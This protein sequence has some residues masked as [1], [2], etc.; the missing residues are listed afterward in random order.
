MTLW[1]CS[2]CGVEQADTEQPAEL[3]AICIDDRQYIRPS[4]QAWTTLAELEA[5]GRTGAVAEV[6]PGLHGVTVTPGVGIGQRSFLVR[7]EHGNLLWDPVGYLDDELV[8]QV[9]AVGGVAAIAASHPHMF[10]VQTEWSRRFDGAPVYVC[11]PDEEWIQR[12]DEVIRR[13][14]D[15]I[16]V[17]PGIRLLQVGGHFRG[18]AVAHLVGADGEG[19]LLSGDTA[20]GTPDQKWASFLRSYPNKIPLSANTVRRIADRLAELSFDR[21]Y[22]N[23]QGLI[24]AD[25]SAAVARSAERYIGWVSGNFDDLT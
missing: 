23:T 8:A 12:D 22:D 2:T 21:M 17:L 20:V 5:G 3:C 15:E 4:G 25:G 19:V 1:I 10:G 18:S 7:T 16:E 13:W 11:R 24:A 9:R 6:E 14:E